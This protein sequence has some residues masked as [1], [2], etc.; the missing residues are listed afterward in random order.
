MKR[1]PHGATY[2]WCNEVTA[3]PVALARHLDRGDLHVVAKSFAT[4]D[5]GMKLR[6]LSNLVFD[7]ALSD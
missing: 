5:D 2:V 6:G 3:Y 1:A 7:H 4:G